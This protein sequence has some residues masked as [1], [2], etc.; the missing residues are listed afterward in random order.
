MKSTENC[1]EEDR[2]TEARGEFPGQHDGR[3][4]PALTA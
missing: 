4:L 1:Y 3:F 2:L